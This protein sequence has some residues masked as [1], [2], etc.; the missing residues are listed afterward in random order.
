MSERDVF[1]VHTWNF[2]QGDR[3]VEGILR[4]LPGHSTLVVRNQWR[5]VLATLA[6][7]HDLG[8]VEWF[9]RGFRGSLKV[10]ANAIILP[11]LEP[12]AMSREHF[13]QQVV[14]PAY[15]IRVVPQSIFQPKEAL[16]VL[17]SSFDW[18]EQPAFDMMLEHIHRHQGL[19]VFVMPLGASLPS[20]IQLSQLSHWT[21]I[22][23][24]GLNALLSA[25]LEEILWEYQPH[26]ISVVGAPDIRV[27]Y[28]AIGAADHLIGQ[29]EGNL[30]AETCWQMGQ[31]VRV[32]SSAV[33]WN[34]GEM[35]TGQGHL[36]QHLQAELKVSDIATDYRFNAT[37]EPIAIDILHS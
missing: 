30:S 22:A 33:Y 32:V 36:L 1:Q 37:S 25:T 34:K 15:G 18:S 10:P 24:T 5:H 8:A 14:L 28:T 16:I 4:E 27:I 7:I 2:L 35:S 13:W 21:A 6:G 31:R 11:W 17:L 19:V 3:D 26:G 20:H 9:A 12:N 23:Y 29:Q